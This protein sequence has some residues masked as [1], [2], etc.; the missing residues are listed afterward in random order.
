MDLLE[1]RAMKGFS[2]TY[3]LFAFVLCLC[4][5]LSFAEAAIIID[6][7]FTSGGGLT[8]IINDCCAF[9]GQ[10]YTA[11]ITGTL[12]GVSVDVVYLEHTP[13]FNFP[14]DVQIRTLNAG[15]PSTTILGET[16][17]TAFSLSDVISFPQVIPQI[18]GVGYAIVVDFLGAPPQGN[19]V[20]LWLG[21]PGNL[22][23]GGGDMLSFDHGVTWVATGPDNFDSHF[24]TLVS[25]AVVEPSSLLLAVPGLLYLTV[26]RAVRRKPTGA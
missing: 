19:P 23:P 24:E 25:T 20:G 12:A 2:R 6:Q 8:T 11:G 17:T 18:A 10:T 26:F 1:E 5:R 9:V 15:L 22:Y 7:S 21:A 3:I 4:T 14:L 13:P 16:S